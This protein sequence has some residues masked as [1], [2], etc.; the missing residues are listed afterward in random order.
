MSE[1]TPK[2]GDVWADKDGEM[3]IVK[4]VSVSESSMRYL[5]TWC[6]REVCDSS[7]DMGEMKLIVR[8]CKPYPPVAASPPEDAVRVECAVMIDND[9]E[10]FVEGMEKRSAESLV[11]LYGNPLTAIVPV[12]VPVSLRKLTPPVLPAVVVQP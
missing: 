4:S 7:L 2:V 9:G 8:D 3:L 11:A 6:D 5:A 10:F 12:M 1:I